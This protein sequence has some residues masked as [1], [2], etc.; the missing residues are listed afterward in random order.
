MGPG[1]EGRLLRA[2]F[3]KRGDE[4]FDGD[5][6]ALEELSY[7]LAGEVGD[8]AVELSFNCCQSPARELRL[9]VMSVRNNAG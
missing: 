8:F 3:S 5:F 7:G 6:G 1:V 4:G 2:R 9:E